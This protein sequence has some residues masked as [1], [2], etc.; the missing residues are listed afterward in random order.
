MN[1]QNTFVMASRTDG[2]G[3]SVLTSVPELEEGKKIRGVVQMLHGMCEYK[4]R[5]QSLL[6]YLNDREFACVIHDHRGHGGGRQGS[7]RCAGAQ[8]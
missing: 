2:L 8:E 6:K 4:E 3:I 1:E 5:Y 7:R